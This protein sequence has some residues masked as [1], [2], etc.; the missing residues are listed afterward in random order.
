MATEGRL[1]IKT[2][3]MVC[4]MVVCANAGDL[5]LK[6]GM[7]QIGND[8]MHR[9][10]KER[11]RLYWL[12]IAISKIG[13]Q[14]LRREGVRAPAVSRS[15]QVKRLARADPAQPNALEAVA[16]AQ[17]EPVAAPKGG[18]MFIQR[19]GVDTHRAGSC[20]LGVLGQR[21]MID[22]DMVGRDHL[23]YHVI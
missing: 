20:V 12:Q 6:R 8:S 4:A 7:L 13:A 16:D 18:D 5:M 10:G 11:L 3:V 2:L 9:A 14:R 21:K 1:R 15:E 22:L 19:R 23:P 17:V